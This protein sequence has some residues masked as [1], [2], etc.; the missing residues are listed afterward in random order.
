[1]LTCGDLAK[2]AVVFPGVNAI[3]LSP[4]NFKYLG[5]ISNQIRPVG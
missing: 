3:W 4:H 1:M 5:A 2:V